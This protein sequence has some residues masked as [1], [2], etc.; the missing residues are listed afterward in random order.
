MSASDYLENKMLDHTFG[1]AEFTMPT[2][3]IALCTSAPT[4]S[5]TGST[6]TEASYTSYARVETD[7]DDWNSASG[8]SID[9]AQAI[10]FPK[11]TGGTSSVTHFAVLDAATNGNLLTKGALGDTLAVANLIIPTFPA[12]T[13]VTD[14]D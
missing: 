2:A 8:G 11:C 3:F 13:L 10:T 5:D 4:D 1:K 12:S 9:N 14:C 6:I 7:S